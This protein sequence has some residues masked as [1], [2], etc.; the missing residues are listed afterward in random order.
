MYKTPKSSKK[1]YQKCHATLANLFQYR[2]R[3]ALQFRFMFVQYAS[4]FAET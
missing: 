4:T 2:A 3:D 1:F